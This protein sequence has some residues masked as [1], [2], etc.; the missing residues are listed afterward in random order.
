MGAATRYKDGSVVLGG[1]RRYTFASAPPRVTFKV[2]V[3]PP[4]DLGGRTPGLLPAAGGKVRL[5]REGQLL[6]ATWQEGDVAVSYSGQAQNERPLQGR[7]A[8]KPGSRV[9]LGSL[10]VDVVRFQ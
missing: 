6:V 8:L 1:G 5:T 4:A 10:A 7:H 9:R 3:A 2:Q